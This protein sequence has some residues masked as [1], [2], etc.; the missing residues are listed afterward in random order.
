MYFEDLLEEG[1]LQSSL[2]ILEKDYED[3][4][5]IRGELD[6]RMFI[7]ETDSLLGSGSLSGGA[8]NMCSRKV[9]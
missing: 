4:I 5:H 1:S 6:E 9:C 3:A 7:D 8:I 2:N